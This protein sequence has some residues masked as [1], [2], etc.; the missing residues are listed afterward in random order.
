MCRIKGSLKSES[1]IVFWYVARVIHLGK[2]KVIKI[3]I[4][5]HMFIRSLAVKLKKI[6]SEVAR[7]F[8][9]HTNTQTKTDIL[10]LLCKDC[11]EG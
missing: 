9:T 11:Y 7:F 2:V 5:L 3:V 6:T 10:L 1:S 4:N 8:A